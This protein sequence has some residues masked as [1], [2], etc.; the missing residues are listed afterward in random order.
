MKWINPGMMELFSATE[1]GSNVFTITKA[2]A[3]SNSGYKN[4]HWTQ[5]MSNQRYQLL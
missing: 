4:A 3:A 1:G 5:S 2:M